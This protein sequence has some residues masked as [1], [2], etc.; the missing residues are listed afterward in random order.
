[1]SKTIL[2][3]IILLFFVVSSIC[4]ANN[5]IIQ[6]PY[7]HG[8]HS[9]SSFEWWNFFGHLIDENQNIFGFSLTFFRQPVP[10]QQSLSPWVTDE[11][12]VSHFSIT[13]SAN[14]Q[15][16]YQDKINRTSFDFAGS[17]NTGLQVWNR[18]WQVFMSD[19]NIILRAETKD[20]ALQLQLL[21]IKSP[22]LFGKDG[23]LESDNLYYYALPKLQGS[24][25]LRI[26]ENQ[27]QILKVSG[28]MDH[29]F[30]ENNKIGFTWDKF[31][32]Q[33]NNGD[34]I[35]I[36]ILAAKNNVF[37]YPES[38]CIINRA[39]GTT[40]R[41][42]LGDFQLTQSKIWYSE[43]SGFS[44]PSG[45]ELAIPALHYHLKL[46]P[47]VRAQ[48][49]VSS[50]AIYWGGQDAVTGKRDGEPVTGYAYIELSPDINRSYLL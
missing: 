15:F 1:M 39:D 40:E 18:G 46:T 47:T 21:P 7:D 19:A 45:W 30:V 4:A 8:K 37:I 25:Q 26:G 20:A 5:K 32:I 36:Y 12:Y 2:L 9:Q 31:A 10:P 27:H 42:K 49:V 14:N 22:I 3:K 50:H 35:L 6:F 17:S 16:Y 24:G 41:L 23:Y 13:D 33:L 48:E 11:I 29:A 38:F 28:V 43:N 44:Y 34:D